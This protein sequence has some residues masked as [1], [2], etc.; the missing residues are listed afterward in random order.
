MFNPTRLSVFILAAVSAACG[1][2]WPGRFDALTI[3]CGTSAAILAGVALTV[4]TL[5]QQRA[6][7]TPPPMTPAPD[8][9]PPAAIDPDHLARAFDQSLRQHARAL[10]TDAPRDHV[11]VCRCPE[12][13]EV[14]LS[15][16]STD[17]AGLRR[18]AAERGLKVERIAEAWIGGE[19]DPDARQ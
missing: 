5:R 11:A 2:A 4:R 14:R 17:G 15:E 1:L 3:T 19:T 16:R 8:P 10:R 13:R 6:E 7:P 9:P 18:M 12:G